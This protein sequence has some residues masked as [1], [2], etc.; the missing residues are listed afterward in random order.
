MDSP[1]SLRIGQLPWFPAIDDEDD[2]DDEDYTPDVESSTDEEPLEYSE[3][4]EPD[5]A[6]PIAFNGEDS[7]IA[8]RKDMY[9]FTK[10]Y[11]R[12]ADDLC[13]SPNLVESAI[14][15]KSLGL[16]FEIGVLL[17]TWIER[18]DE[19]G[20]GRWVD[21][22]WMKWDIEDQAEREIVEPI[23]QDLYTMN[24]CELKYGYRRQEIICDFQSHWQM[25][26]D[27]W[28]KFKDRWVAKL[29]RAME[30][31]HEGRIYVSY[32]DIHEEPSDP[33]LNV[34]YMILKYIGRFMMDEYVTQ[35]AIEALKDVVYRL[36]TSVKPI[37]QSPDEYV[38]QLVATLDSMG[39]QASKLTFFPEES[40]GEAIGNKKYLNDRRVYKL[41]FLFISFLLRQAMEIRWHADSK[42]IQLRDVEQAV[43]CM[44]REHPSPV[45]DR[46]RAKI[47][48]YVRMQRVFF[49]A[50]ERRYAPG[51]EGAQQAAISFASLVSTERVELV[52]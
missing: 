47:M 27:A 11:N 39:L 15:I 52:P 32:S 4:D 38:R 2:P 35:A 36:L 7:I 3:Q 19:C 10:R 30:L 14:R 20:D 18:F 44:L 24:L 13:E 5:P 37:H 33:A 46:T 50:S 9:T 40:N 22:D 34:E 26:W 1:H 8:L 17:W 25:I 21:T 23:L 12:R 6:S 45:W 41:V 49:E 43:A 51:G 16:H 48:A 29:E 31:I 28:Q 42:V